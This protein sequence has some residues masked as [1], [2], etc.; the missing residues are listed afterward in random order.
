MTKKSIQR[1][2]IQPDMRGRPDMPGVLNLLW[3]KS[4]YTMTDGELAGI[5]G[6]TSTVSDT[7]EQLSDMLIEIACVDGAASSSP[8]A[9]Y[10][11]ISDLSTVLFPLVECL[12][13]Q[14]AL[15]Q[16]ADH[17]TAMLLQPSV[18]RKGKP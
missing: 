4:R 15:L 6:A 9:K 16:V 18:Y 3:E 2:D 17:A 7:L 12:S 10:G 8:D 13:A 5:A 14:A 1:A 11:C